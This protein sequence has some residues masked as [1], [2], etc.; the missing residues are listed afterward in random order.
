MTPMPRRAA[1]HGAQLSQVLPRR[2][3]L[4]EGILPNKASEWEEGTVKTTTE[5]KQVQVVF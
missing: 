4:T 5:K 2:W 3:W 1:P